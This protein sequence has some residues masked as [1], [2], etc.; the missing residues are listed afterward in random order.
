MPRLKNIVKSVVFNSK[1]LLIPFLLKLIYTLIVLAYDFII[2]GHITNENMMEI[3][4][5]VD[6]V[7]VASLI[8]MIISG[9]YHSLI[10]KY[11]GFE[12]EGV[13]SWLL[14]IKL[15]S[16]IIG[17]ASIH[18]LQSFVIA[19]KLT[20]EVVQRQCLIFGMFLFGALVLSIIDFL[21]FKSES[22]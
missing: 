16:S 5:A 4:E 15:A 19:N 13:S 14:K 7:M 8:K 2:D 17:V 21:H 18:L 10:D 20:D 6:V 12:D 3:L 11:H 22:H 9:T 1:W